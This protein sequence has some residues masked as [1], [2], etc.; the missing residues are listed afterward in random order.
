MK[1]SCDTENTYKLPNDLILV[2][3][4]YI[5]KITDKRQ[6]LRTCK[7]INFITKD[8]ITR[9]EYTYYDN[10][11]MIK[12]Y[13]CNEHITK[14]YYDDLTKF[15]LELCVDSYFDKIPISYFNKNNRRI[16]YFLIKYGQL[17][18][19]KFA[20]KNG[21][22]WVYSEGWSWHYNSCEKAAHFGQLEILKYLHIFERTSNCFIDYMTVIRAA[23]RG[24]LEMLEWIKG[25]VNDWEHIK[26]DRRICSEAAL[27]GHLDTLIW[28]RTN[29]CP[30]DERTC[31]DAATN[32]HL[33]VIKWARENGC[34]WNIFTCACAKNNGHLHVLEWARTNGCP[35]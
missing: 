1:H 30:W 27:N 9:D 33:H 22:D 28:A 32:G 16:I 17:E 26:Q 5:N 23:G 13:G 6:F 24:D 4:G 8:M 19:F 31:S 18:L 21:C 14:E 34:R 20:R 11:I 12:H 7:R 35:G 3:F 25:N 15:T 29:G 2:I 10:H